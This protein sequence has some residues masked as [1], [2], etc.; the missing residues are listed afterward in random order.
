MCV[1][2]FGLV[3]GVAVP[4]VGDPDPSGEPHGCVAH[5]DLAVGA[6]IHVADLGDAVADRT[7]P[8][9]VATHARHLLDQ[10]RRQLACP[11]GIEQHPDP[12]AST[13]GSRQGVGESS[14]DVTAPVDE[15]DE[16]DVRLRCVDGFQHRRE[17]L[18]TV[19]EDADF[20][21]GG[22]RGPQQRLEPQLP[23]FRRRPGALR[24]GA[25]SD[26]RFGGTVR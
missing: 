8:S 19:S 3:A 26:D 22:R 15:G 13:G 23:T 16:V 18:V 21:A 4:L 5:E 25:T 14:S 24:V 17:D 7:E 9:H 20:V 12:T 1:A 2:P 11:D 6:V 10:F